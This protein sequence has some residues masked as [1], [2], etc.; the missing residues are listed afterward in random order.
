MFEREERIALFLL[1][2]VMLILVSAY[3]VLDFTGKGLFAVPYTDQSPDGQLVILNGTADKITPLANGGHII[4]ECNGATIF[5]P[6][7]IAEKI[8]VHKGEKLMIYGTVQTY[9]GK[10]EIMVNDARDISKIS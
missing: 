9:R 2:G 3:L 7:Q 5:I 10:K 1:I 8:S 6:S 4:I